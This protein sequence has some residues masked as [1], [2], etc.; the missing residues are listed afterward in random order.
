[1]KKISLF[2]MLCF[3]TSAV[4]AQTIEDLYVSSTG[5]ASW[6]G[7]YFH[8]FRVRVDGQLELETEHPYYQY[9]VDGFVEGEVHNIMVAPIV[10]GNVGLYVVQIMCRDAKIMSQQVAISR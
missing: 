9:D 10:D 1:M 2:L 8:E 3:V 7:V 4:K 6:T 5:W